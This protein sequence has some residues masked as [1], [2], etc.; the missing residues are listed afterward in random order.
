MTLVSVIIPAYNKADY[1]RRAIDSVLA[2]TYAPIEL[3]VVDDGSKDNTADVVKSYGDAVTYVAKP[4]GGACSARNEGIRRAK[5]EY[6][7]FLDCDDLYEPAKINTSVN[8]LQEH[9]Q[10]GFVHTDAYFID[11][12][13]RVTGQYKHPLSF[14]H[15]GMIAEH[16]IL[17]NFICNSTVLVRR[18]IIDRVGLFD[19]TLFPPA[20]WDMWLRYA[21]VAEVGFI[22]TALTKYRVADNFIFNRLDQSLAEEQ[23]VLDKYFVRNPLASDD[24]KDEARGRLHARFAQSYFLKGET[25]KFKKQLLLA[26]KA[27]L[28][29]WKL[30]VLTVGCYFFPALMRKELKRRI[31]R[32]G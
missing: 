21:Q 22:P 24:L 15:Q 8:Y 30:L 3:I 18:S 26:Q 28:L 10:A 4:N 6:I 1:T 12:D 17:G 27:D 7:A 23:I 32:T 11:A 13:D 14:R 9:P 19:E 20:D 25:D 16:L 2:Q 29:N 5:G 31:L